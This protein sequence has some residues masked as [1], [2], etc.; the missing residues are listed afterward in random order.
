MAEEIIFL[1]RVDDQV[2][3]RGFRV[4][5]NEV[6]NAIKNYAEIIQV[7]VIVKGEEYNEKKLVA[8]ITVNKLEIFSLKKL[9]NHLK[10][11]L[12]QYMIPTKFVVLDKMPIT[13]NGKVDKNALHANNSDALAV[14]NSEFDLPTTI[15]EKRLCE[16]WEDLLEVKY[17]GIND[18]FFEIGGHSLLATQLLTRIRSEFKVLLDYKVLF[19]D[20]TI[21]NLANEINNQIKKYGELTQLGNNSKYENEEIGI[22]MQRGESNIAPV[23]FIH[24]LRGGLLCFSKL[25]PSLEFN[26]NIFGVESIGYSTD[27]DS[28]SNV[29]EMAEIYTKRI[30]DLGIKDNCTLIGYSFSGIIALEVARNLERLGKKINSL[31]LLDSHTFTQSVKEEAN[32]SLRSFLAHKKLMKS[33]NSSLDVI[34]SEITRLIGYNIPKNKISIERDL[35]V[36]TANLK[37]IVDYEINP[38]KINSDIYLFRVRDNPNSDELYN[39]WKTATKGNYVEQFISGSHLTIVESPFVESLAKKIDAYL[40]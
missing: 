12:P 1:G 16:I 29:M 3:I 13:K 40:S 22:L 23:I 36:R 24:P 14:V 10:G 19:R 15:T 39:Q 38:E 26:G 33:D 25:I 31:I 4:E 28:L 20:L 35:K 8:F 32:N 30:L 11:F 34:Y 6:E 17:I 27:R 5:I 9:K 21:C 7:S 18:D 37:A 2:K